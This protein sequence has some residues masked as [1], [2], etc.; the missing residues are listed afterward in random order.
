MSSSKLFE[1]KP[2]DQDWPV[3]DIERVDT[4]PYCG[5]HERTLAYEDVQDWSFNCAPGKWNYWDCVSCQSLYLDPRPT[6]STIV[7]AY[8]KYFTHGSGKPVPFVQVMKARLRNECLSQKLSVNIEPRL[9]LP[10]LL[11][12]FVALISKRVAVPFG[13]TSLA[14]RP[15]GRFMDVGCGAGLAVAFARQLGWDAMGLEIDPTAVREAQRTGLNIVQG[16]Y[17]QLTQYERQFDC[18]MCSHVLEHVH[19]PRNLLAQLKVAIKP[20]GVLLLSLPNSLSAMRRHFGANWRGLEAPRHLSIPSESRLLQ[21][22]TESGFSMQSIVGS[23]IETAAESYRIQRRGLVI[24]RQDIAMARQLD[25][26]PLAT[27]DGNDFIQFV[28][29]ASAVPST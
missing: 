5:S 23:G 25:I 4:C 7:A 29:E 27:A 6:R 10:K 1:N 17:E 9:H 13:W 15:R 19:E 14:S 2:L 22:L 26:Q 12:G 16:T 3:E 21:L 24:S 28:C 18:I 20:G 8:A 11:D